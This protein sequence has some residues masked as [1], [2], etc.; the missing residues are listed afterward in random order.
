MRSFIKVKIEQIFH[1]QKQAKIS[2]LYM[3]RIYLKTQKTTENYI[4]KLKHQKTHTEKLYQKADWG[5][6]K[7]RANPS[8]N[9]WV[10]LH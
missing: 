2:G 10:R 9:P 5:R 6:G 8:Q 1:Y 7:G 3:F 4:N